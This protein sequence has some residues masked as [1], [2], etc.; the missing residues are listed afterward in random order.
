MVRPDHICDLLQVL[1]KLAPTCFMVRLLVTE[2]SAPPGF[3]LWRVY[4]Y[5]HP[6]GLKTK[7]VKG[8]RSSVSQW[9]S[10]YGAQLQTLMSSYSWVTF[11]SEVDG[12]I[13]TSATIKNNNN[14]K[15]KTVS[16]GVRPVQLPFAG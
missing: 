5:G 6:A 4:G 13:C 14:K 3:L 8:Q 9:A 16:V 10:I 12:R 7:L 15:L 2:Q 11:S 1:C